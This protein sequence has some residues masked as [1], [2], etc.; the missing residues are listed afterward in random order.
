MYPNL[1]LAITSVCMLQA[2]M[3]W[4]FSHLCTHYVAN[5]SIYV[6]YILYNTTDCLKE[7]LDTLVRVHFI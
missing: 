5:N 2:D 3:P 7:L 4:V 1:A 6:A